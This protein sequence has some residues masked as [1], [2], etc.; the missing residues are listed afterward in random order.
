MEISINVTSGF[1]NPILQENSKLSLD[2]PVATFSIDGET[3]CNDESCTMYI[4]QE[5]I[6]KTRFFRF[7]GVYNG[8]LPRQIFSYPIFHNGNT[9]FIIAFM[10]SGA[11]TGSDVL[12]DKATIYSINITNVGDAKHKLPK[13]G[14]DNCLPCPSMDS[15]GRCHPCPAGHYIDSKQNVCVRCPLGTR[16]NRT[17]HQI[18]PESCV[19]CGIN[20]E[21]IDGVEC[22]FNGKLTLPDNI[23]STKK[24]MKFDLS[25]LKN[26]PLIAE[27]IKVFAR[28]G[29]SYFHSFNVS[30]F[31][32][33]VK[34]GDKSELQ[35]F[36]FTKP[37]NE[38]KVSARTRNISE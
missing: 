29:N 32:E 19:K 17:A 4:V 26:K 11:A 36:V 25:L 31:G 23:E 5:V 15:I 14:A 33:G 2:N 8:S 22:A 1:Y 3:N 37:I 28:E 12:S 24:P 27:G 16:L 34:C 18:G 7:L 13:G 6:E 35:P 30:L 9:R 20:M 38:E 21:S 10:R